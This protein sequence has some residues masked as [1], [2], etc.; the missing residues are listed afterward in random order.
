[1]TYPGSIDRGGGFTTTKKAFLELR[2][3]ALAEPVFTHHWFSEDEADV[4]G[5]LV[6]WR[7][8]S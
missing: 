8:R 2:T 5:Q 6:G 1:V 7:F 4:C 3:V